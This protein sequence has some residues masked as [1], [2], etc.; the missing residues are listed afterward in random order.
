MNVLYKTRC[1]GI[2]RAILTFTAI[3]LC[4]SANA[5]VMPVNDVSNVVFTEGLSSIDTNG[6]TMSGLKVTA[7]FADGSS[8]TLTWGSTGSNSGGVS[9][10][11]WS[12][13][14][15]GSSSNNSTSSF[16]NLWQFENSTRP[17]L[18]KL[19][20]DGRGTT[21]VF[22]RSEPNPGTTNSQQGRDFFPVVIDGNGDFAELSSDSTATYSNPI[23][24]LN[25]DPLEDL[26]LLLNID[27]ENGVD[28]DFQFALDT[29]TSVNVIPLPGALIF[30]GSGLVFL[31]FWGRTKNATA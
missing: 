23:A 6:A 20:L 12:L 29:E 13:S 5:V 17:K 22:D 21:T 2:S 14:L 18:E 8:E 16:N 7:G 27:I 3:V 19:T 10:M 1:T 28:G 25:A 30:I 31:G 26:W 15:G 4:A 9:G 11:G 24:L